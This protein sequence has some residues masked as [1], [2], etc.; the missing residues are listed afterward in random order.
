M[1]AKTTQ[2]IKDLDLSIGCPRI[3]N[4]PDI[5]PLEYYNYLEKQKS[6][7]WVGVEEL[8]QEFW[9]WG[10]INEELFLESS[11]TEESY[12]GFC[13]ALKQLRELFGEEKK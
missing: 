3:G 11:I 5:N 9:E 8:K 12:D 6:K 2:E 7:R 13:Q 4:T 1:I 10:Q